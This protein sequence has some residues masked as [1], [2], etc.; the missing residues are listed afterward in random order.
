[1]MCSMGLVYG[2]NSRVDT[3][4]SSSWDTRRDS[5]DLD[6]DTVGF[7]R[8]GKQKNDDCS[9]FEVHR[10][11]SIRTRLFLRKGHLPA[12]S[13]KTPT[14]RLLYSDFSYAC[15][16]LVVVIPCYTRKCINP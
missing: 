13:I 3:K 5:S 7:G 9:R 16:Y 8:K 4:N 2:Y 15:L 10:I 11:I 1:M 14:F 6:G 12:F